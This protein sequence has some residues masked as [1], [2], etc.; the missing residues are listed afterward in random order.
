[1][2][3]DEMM[4]MSKVMIRYFESFSDSVKEMDQQLE[5]LSLG[6]RFFMRQLEQVRTFFLTNIQGSFGNM[7]KKTMDFSAYFIKI[8]LGLVLAIYFFRSSYASLE[9]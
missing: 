9:P 8:G 2:K 3:S 6:D 1:M 5:K 7:M 4:S